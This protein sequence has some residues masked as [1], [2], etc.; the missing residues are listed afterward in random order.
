MGRGGGG[1]AGYEG[2]GLHRT[3]S[4]ARQ[5]IASGQW[6]SRKRDWWS[7]GGAGAGGGG[8]GK[9]GGG[10]WGDDSTSAAGHPPLPPHII[11]PNEKAYL[12]W[13]LATLAAALWTGIFDPCVS[14]F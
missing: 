10:A 6:V 8:G 14:I 7:A 3:S 12:Y 13:F 1:G 5:P 2:A 9:H 11:L 4:I